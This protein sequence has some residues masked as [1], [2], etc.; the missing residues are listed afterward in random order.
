[1]G[2]FP[3]LGLKFG[4]FFFGANWLL[5]SGRGR[6]QPTSDKNSRNLGLNPNFKLPK[7][8]LLELGISDAGPQDF[9]P[10]NSPRKFRLPGSS[11]NRS[12]K[13]RSIFRDVCFF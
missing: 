7:L 12:W 8:A 4:R 6:V 9:R 3:F 11:R 10:R 2:L 5:V 13:Q 1:M